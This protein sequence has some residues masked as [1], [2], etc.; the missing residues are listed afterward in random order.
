MASPQSTPLI[1]TCAGGLEPVL[2]Q[3]ITERGWQVVASEAG[4]VRF[5]G[6]ESAVAEAN[7]VLRTASRILV[8]VTPGGLDELNMA[9]TVALPVAPHGEEQVR[10]ID[11]RPR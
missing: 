2:T 1:A 11:A 3:E 5:T 4:A 10:L 8:P 7:I 9:G 6:P